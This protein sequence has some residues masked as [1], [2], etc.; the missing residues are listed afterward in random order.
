MT[1]SKNT[2]RILWRWH[3]YAGLFCIPFIIILSISGSI[4]LF[5]PQIENL[6]EAGYVAASTTGARSLPAQQID[7]AMSSM[8]DAKFRSYRLPQNDQEAIKITAVK[9]QQAYFIYLNPYTLS[10]MDIVA[11]D[12]RFIE[13]IREL[14]GSLLVGENGSLLVE[15]AACWTIFLVLSGMYLWWPKDSNGMAG[16]IYPRLKEGGRRFWRDLHAVIGMWISIFVLFL[17]ISGLPWTQVW[18]AGF[19]EVRKAVTHMTSSDWS[20]NKKEQQQTLQRQSRAYI[21]LSNDVYQKSLTLGFAA[22]LELSV[23]DA[24]NKIWKV[25][26]RSQNMTLSQNAWLDSTG[27]IIKHTDF[28]DKALLDRIIGVG[29]SAH[30]GQL[31]GW[32]NQL[33]GVITALGLL[34]LSISGFILWRKRKPAKRLGAPN[35]LQEQKLAKSKGIVVLMGIL[36]ALLPMLLMSLIVIILLEKLVFPKLPKVQDFLGLADR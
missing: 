34:T 7:A 32:A 8:P 36:A 26:S 17:L 21:P 25:S 33:L 3:F 27:K 20:I 9:N 1:N 24:D 18:G 31:F 35:K 5:K 16:V 28:N 22:P 2:Y 12:S 29:I 23:A 30:E 11:S 15:L 10:V 4:Y 19:K 13:W 14:H 6:R